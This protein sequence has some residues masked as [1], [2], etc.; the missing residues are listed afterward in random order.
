MRACVVGLGKVGL[1]LAVQYASR[2]LSVIGCDTDA[3]KVEQINAG[4]CPV[5]G[6]EGLEEGLKAALREGRLHATIDTAA[7]VAESVVAVI[8]VPVGLTA[9]RRPDFSHLDAATEA[10]ASGLRPGTLVL[11][12]S[13][14]PVGTTRGRVGAALAAGGRRLG[15]DVLLAASPERVSTGRIFRDLR[16]Y[17]KLIGPL[18]EASWARADAFY[19]AALEAPC[20]LRVRDPET[21]EFAKLAEGL[22]RDVNIA[23]VDELARYAD[24]LGIDVTEAIAAANSQ[25]YSHLHQPGVGVGGHCLP[26]YPYFLP[27]EAS[28]R[29]PAAARSINDAMARYGVEKLEGALGSLR[30]ATVLI[31]GLAYRPNVK[32]AAHSSALPLAEAL[33]E[34]GARVLVHDPWFSDEEV[35]AL[36]LEP[37]SKF[38]PSHVDALIVQALHDAYRDLDLR[39]FAGCRAV[40]DGRNA[41]DRSTVEAAGLR[42]LGIGR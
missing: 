20:L 8:I 37:S 29:L 11:V 2:G 14:V 40:L 32:E 4:E 35:R 10:L 36:G 15:V 28:L 3:A 31:L 39:S 7:A 22:Y 23:L 16:T 1:P 13:T 34:R 12:E 9:D 6:E 27:E 21:A 30:G 42:Y 19:R 33:Q 41:L 24:A 5:V 26:V 17:P 18:D 25:P 38:P